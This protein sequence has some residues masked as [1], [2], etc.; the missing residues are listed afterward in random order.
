MFSQNPQVAALTLCFGVFELDLQSGELRKAGRLIKLPP[1]PLRI[2]TL[3]ATRKDVVTR[4]EIQKQIWSDATYVDFERGIN[5]CISQIRSALDDNTGTP[6]YVQ[7]LPRRGYRFVAPVVEREHDKIQPPERIPSLEPRTAAR[8]AL[9]AFCL[10]VVLAGG[11]FGW[12]HISTEQNLQRSKVPLAVLPFVNL[13]GDPQQDYFAEGM[14]EALITQLG[15]FSRL[16]VISNQTVMHFNGINSPA[17]EIARQLNVNEIVKGF[18]LQSNGKVRISAQLIDPA[19]GTYVWTGSYEGD[20]RDVL[21]IQREVADG[22]ASKIRVTMTPQERQRVR[23]DEEV[24]PAAHEAYLRGRY[25]SSK[26]TRQALDKSIEYFLSAVKEDPNYAPAY[27]GLADSYNLLAYSGAL[28]PKVAYPEA[29]TAA[30]KALQLDD[31]SAD[32]HTSLADIRSVYEWKWSE[33]EAEY[34]RAIEL[35]SSYAIAH[36]W[37][38]SYLGAMGRPKE[39]VLEAKQALGLDPLSLV[40]NSNVGWSYYLAGR[41]DDAIASWQSTLEMDSAFGLAHLDL[42]RAYQQKNMHEPAISEMLKAIALSGETP[43]ALAALGYSYAAAGKPTQTI[44]IVN[45][46]KTMAE[47][48]YVPAYD[49]AVLYAGLGKRDDALN[50]LQEAY[51]ERCGELLYIKVDPRLDSLRDDPRFAALTRD[52]GLQ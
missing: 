26:R 39:S 31:T 35:N 27:A 46:L 11:V 20:L 45:R 51:G 30:M 22:I 5:H 14:T 44:E 50:W 41:Y 17:S 33:A 52:M 32:A 7:T 43:A 3:L 8:F 29:T 40:I 49:L 48:S 19:S 36:Q 10:I 15:K 34:R 18:V 37:Y 28:P 16:R 6:R 47:T 21:T 13:S 9:V 42:G 1:Q 38:A 24:N 12:R 25:Y 2:L 23:S 4:D